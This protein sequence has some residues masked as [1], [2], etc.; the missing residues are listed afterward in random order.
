MAGLGVLA[1]FGT[2][3]WMY[4]NHDH[5]DQIDD[6]VVAEAVSSAC[7]TMTDKVRTAVVPPRSSPAVRVAAI[8]RQNQAVWDF[9]EE[10]LTVGNE[11]LDGD[12]PS[13]RWL[14]DWETI[15]SLRERAAVALAVGSAPS[16]TMPSVEGHPIVERMNRTSD[17]VVPVELTTLP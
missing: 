14:Q 15:M 16:F 17:C 13:R 11:R 9:V 10:V 6:P 4:M 2:G 8:R 3:L 12:L 7:A 1:V 5:I